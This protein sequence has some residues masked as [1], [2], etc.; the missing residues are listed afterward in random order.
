MNL[1][2]TPTT[3]SSNKGAYLHSGRYVLH[4]IS[5]SLTK[6]LPLF[7]KLIFLLSQNLVAAPKVILV[8]MS[9]SISTRFTS[10]AAHATALALSLGCIVDARQSVA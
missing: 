10:G 6:L 4:L 3:A 5:A 8:S 9:S 7:I 1:S 2:A